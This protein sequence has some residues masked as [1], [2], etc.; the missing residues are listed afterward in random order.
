MGKFQSLENMVLATAEAVRPPERLTVAESAEKYRFVNNPGSYVGPFKNDTTPYLVEP[1]EVLNSLDFTG[2][3]FVGPA[4]CGKSDMSLNWLNHS[5][6]CDPAD[7]M[8]IDKSQSAARDWHQRRVEKL[9]RDNPEIRN[10][11]LPGKQN[12]ST[13]STKFTSGMLYTLSWPTVN[14]LSG[15]PVGRLWLADYDR[16]DED[17]GGEGSPYDLASQRMKTFKRF[18]MCAAESSPSRVIENSR[19]IPQTPHQAPPT[20][21]ILALY[22]RGDR[23]RWYWPCLSCGTPFEPD[24]SLFKWPDTDDLLA[25]AEQVVLECPHCA[26]PF[27]DS[28]HEESGTPGKRGMNKR[29]FWLR[30]NEKMDPESGEIIG[31]PIR[32]LTASFWLKGPA[33]AFADWTDMTLKYLKALAEMEATGSEEALKTTVNTDQ[34]LPFLPAGIEAER[35]PEEVKTRAKDIGEKVV[36]EGVRF[37]IATVDTQKSRFEVQ[38]HGVKPHGDIVVIDRFKIRKANR[39]DEDGDPRPLKPGTYVEDWWLLIDKV[40]EKTYDLA[41]DSGRHMQIRMMAVDSG[42]A[43][44]ATANAYE[45]WRQLR[46]DPEGRNYHRRV[47]LLKGDGRD[48]IPLV[49][50][51]YPNAERKDRR[52]QARGEVPVLMV[53]TNQAKDMVNNMLSREMPGGG[54]VE[55]PDWLPDWWFV[56]LCAETK[57]AKGWVNPGQQRNEA[58]DLLVYCVALCHS[59][60]IG[61]PHINWDKPPAWAAEWD[62]NDL[63]GS[64]N[65]FR[66]EIHP[67]GDNTLK[68]LAERLG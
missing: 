5:A 36:P 56:E 62:V 58:W 44:S 15:K 28:Y 19:W 29:G 21:G 43:E 55:F 32:S 27:R 37:L 66:F 61:L 51:D 68:T 18:G 54:F 22:N 50:I 41:D 9:F 42:G 40:L 47:Q 25:A 45:F 60:K 38:I 16:M 17:V 12:S 33:A 53:N 52:A 24:F 6:I 49:R 10:R 48:K 1:M 64:E 46:S 39:L 8:H 14:E 59:S 65:N 31:E 23:R 20:S 11:L 63:I 30:D 3:A 2:M 4:Q 57:T 35:L 13:Y 67:K 7:F 34:G 26:H